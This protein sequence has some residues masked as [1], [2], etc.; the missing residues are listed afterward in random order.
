MS[1]WEHDLDMSKGH[2]VEGILGLIVTQCRTGVL[3][4]VNE[5]KESRKHTYMYMYMQAHVD[6]REKQ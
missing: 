5:A 3:C 6:L 4:R 1:Q 2:I